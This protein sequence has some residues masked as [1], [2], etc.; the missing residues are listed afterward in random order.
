MGG[1]AS[2]SLRERE[3]ERLI[4]AEGPRLLA[5]AGRFC[6]SESEAE[7]LVQ[8]TF[9][10]AW[11]S[12][13]QLDDRARARPWLY[14]IARH[15]CQRMHRKR[16][17]EPPRLESLD[18]L[19]PRPAPTVPDLRPGADPHLTR[20]R[21]E[22]RELVE[23]GLAT[24]P[25]TFRIPLVL[26]DVA[27]LTIQEISAVL[28]IREA[29]VKTRIHRARLKLRAILAAGLPQRPAP[30]ATHSR[31]LCLDLIAARLAAFDR[32]VDFP[33]S[34]EALCERCRTVLGTLELSRESCAA[35]APESLSPA[36]RAR[37]R[38]GLIR[39]G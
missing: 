12:W 23:R 39:T 29:T 38:S 36:L 8:E 7:D 9:T 34:S 32:G 33:L 20:L 1:S 2:A 24:L 18:E 11:R 37:L 6:G 30:A 22:A 35:L 16:A 31:G 15:A 25:P 10:R 4:D 17:G 26:A 14:A 13:D 5:F 27:E 21:S 3:I 28:G 19:L